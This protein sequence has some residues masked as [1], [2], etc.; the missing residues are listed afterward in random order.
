MPKITDR[1]G[2]PSSGQMPG[3]VEAIV[4]DN[5]DPAELARVRVKFPSLPGPPSGGDEILSYWARLVMPMAGKERGWVTIPEI[6]DEV[7]VAFVHGDFNNAIVIGSLFNGV[8]T[9]P[10]ANEDKEDNLRVFQSRSGHRVTFDDTK[11]EERIELIVFNEEIRII[12][13]AK[14]KVLSVYCGK[15]IIVEAKET[16]SMKCKD[17]ILKADN[18]VSI[19]A[20]ANMDLKAG[21][22]LTAKGG[23]SMVL[24]ASMTQIN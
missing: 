7:L 21:S 22:A 15:D 12:W 4:T 23:N 14:E 8:D 2:R 18:S 9:P 24:T 3:L 20:G 10:Y 19:E 5:V 11:G 13:D 6:G 1:F 17:F 16:I